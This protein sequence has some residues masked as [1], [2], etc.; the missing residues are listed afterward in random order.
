MAGTGL[1]SASDGASSCRETCACDATGHFQCTE[2]CPDA[3]TLNP[4]SDFVVHPTGTTRLTI[5]VT[6]MDGGI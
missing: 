1:S 2:S 6:P 3:S 4:A 5:D